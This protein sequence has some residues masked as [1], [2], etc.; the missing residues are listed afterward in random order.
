MIAKFIDAHTLYEK[1]NRGRHCYIPLAKAGGNCVNG[2]QA[3][4]V[5]A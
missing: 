3:E 1:M 2:G 5:L 4:D